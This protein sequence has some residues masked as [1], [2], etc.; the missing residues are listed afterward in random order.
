M[1]L[2][3]KKLLFD[4]EQAIASVAAFTEGKTFED[5]SG[6]A[7]LRPPRAAEFLRHGKS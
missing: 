7:M 1:Q 6:D 2:E 5:Y 3:A 4:I